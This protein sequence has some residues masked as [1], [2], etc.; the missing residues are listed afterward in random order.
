MKSPSWVFIGAFMGSLNQPVFLL[1]LLN[2]TRCE[3]GVGPKLYGTSR[4]DIFNVMGHFIDY[5]R[6]GS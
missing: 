3:N 4:R 2:L 1:T 6:S 5:F